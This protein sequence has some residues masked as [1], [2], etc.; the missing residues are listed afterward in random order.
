MR[1]TRLPAGSDRT[2]MKVWARMTSTKKSGRDR[3]GILLGLCLDVFTENNFVLSICFLND[4]LTST[5][6]YSG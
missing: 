4:A 6:R 2:G 5:K 1:E 3:S